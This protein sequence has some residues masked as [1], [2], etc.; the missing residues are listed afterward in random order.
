MVASLGRHVSTDQM[1]AFS[2]AH[3]LSVQ[4]RL[5]AQEQSAP[6]VI[7][8]TAKRRLLQAQYVIV[9]VIVSL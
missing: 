5:A 3:R 8:D 1:P 6:S 4:H 2:A 7:H 9:S